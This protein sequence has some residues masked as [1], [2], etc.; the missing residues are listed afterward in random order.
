MTH[1]TNRAGNSLPA[2]RLFRQKVNMKKPITFRIGKDRPITKAEERLIQ[3]ALR[4]KKQLWNNGDGVC[5]AA[6][7]VMKERGMAVE[8]ERKKK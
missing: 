4:F 7:A 1:Q 5:R 6:T 2:P 3:A 8:V